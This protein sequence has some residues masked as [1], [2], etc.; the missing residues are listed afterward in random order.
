MLLAIA[1]VVPVLIFAALSATAVYLNRQNQLR[2]EIVADAHRTSEAIDRELASAVDMAQSL[3]GL[4]QLDGVPEF[5]AFNEIARREQHRHPLWLTVNLLD[6]DGRR[7]TNSRGGSPATAVEPVSVRETVETARP[8]IGSIKKGPLEFGIPIRAPVIRDGRVVYVVTVVI[9]PGGIRDALLA[10]RL[11]HDWIATVVDNSGRVVART[12]NDQAF[13]GGAASPGAL[14]ARKA[15]P[16]G[17][18]EGNTL[19]GISTVSAF[20]LSPT[21]GWSVHIGVPKELAD[22]PLQRSIWLM[23][24]GFAASV[25]LAGLFVALLVRELRLRRRE[26][27]AVEQSGRLEALGR[28]TGGVAHDFN[29]LLM[30]IQGSAEILQRQVKEAR[31]VKA[32]A[33]IRDATGR[34]AKLTRELLVFARG[35]TAEKAVVELGGAVAACL[36]F[37]REAAGAAVEVRADLDPAACPVD[38]DRVQLEVALLNLAVNAR[39]A[40]PDGGVLVVATRR[41]ERHVRLSVTDTGTGIA[42]EVVARVFDP[43]FTTKGPGAGTGLGLTQV[44]SFAKHSGGSAEVASRVGRGTSIT[45]SLP[46]TAEP[47]PATAAPA[48]AL[49]HDGLTGRRILLVDD[50]REVRTLTAAHLRD[51]GAVVVEVAAAAEALARLE[52]D[53]PFD[54]MVSDIAM[55][56]AMNGLALA[57]IV[58]VKWPGMSIVLVSGYSASIAEAGRRGLP[59]LWKPYELDELTRLLN[60]SLGRKAAAG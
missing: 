18:Y 47:I 11:S 45:I 26:A 29:N 8:V 42:P 34:A 9:R 7:L 4:P 40:M 49:D 6:P 31:S 23:V 50:D 39:D 20:W 56:G 53:G 43:F 19:E 44:Y 38:V 10:S 52:T 55:P 59:V 2:E 36:D 25:M 35:G 51:R 57:E 1:A 3:A 54:A 5:E 27:A 17:T 60:E 28:L 48:A 37:V 32:L 14:A 46:L 13:L 33:A 22:A 16:S 21:T 15:A 30:I 58:R 24:G 12:V 41:G